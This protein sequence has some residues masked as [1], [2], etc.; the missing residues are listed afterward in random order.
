MSR[1]LRLRTALETT[2]AYVP[3][4]PPKPKPGLTPHKLSSNEHH[5]EPLPA[6]LDAARDAAGTPNRYPDPSAAAL[7]A[8]LAAHL[9]VGTDQVLVSAGASEMLSSLVRLTAE[10][11]TNVVYPWP[12]FEMYPQLVALSGAEKRAVPLTADFRHDLPAMAAAIDDATRLV[13][14][15]SPNNPTGPVLGSQEF[16]AFMEQVPEDVLVVLDEAYIEFAAEA[17]VV[18]GI[19]ALRSYPNLVVARTFSK[20][21][22]LAG[23]RVGYGVAS[24]EI[25]LELRKAVAPFSVTDVAQAAARA[26]LAHMSEVEVRAKEVGVLRTGLIDALRAQG[27]DV[28]DSWANFV[29]LP[30]G[31]RSAEFEA[32]CLEEGISVRNLGSGVRVSIG[33]AS[34]METVARIAEG[35]APRA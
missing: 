1:S 35:F 33:E 30:L 13:L 16:S 3:G 7:H 4:K 28:P 18:D 8:D 15:C 26:S 31:E 22:G 29:W 11:G 23:F 14:L 20:A 32:A 5:M 10:P 27:W 17:P 12:S 21:H 9:G 19:A 24:P 6:V 34:A 25:V 2:P